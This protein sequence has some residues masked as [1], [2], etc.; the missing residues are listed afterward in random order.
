MLV[1]GP[2]LV[3]PPPAEPTPDDALPLAEFV[4]RARREHIR[5]ALARCDG[6]R[7]RAARELG[8]DARTV[9]R[10]VADEDPA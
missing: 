4:D 6:N 1:I 9:F 3:R 7:S 2:Q 10:F 8:V 5:R